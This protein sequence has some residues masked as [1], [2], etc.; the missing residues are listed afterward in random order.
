MLSSLRFA[1]GGYIL[2]KKALKKLVED[3]LP[4]NLPNCGRDWN[5]IDDLFTGKFK[6]IMNV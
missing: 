2:S 3:I 4:K 5:T 1:G 6:K